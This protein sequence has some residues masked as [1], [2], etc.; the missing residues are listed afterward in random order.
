MRMGTTW[1]SRRMAAA[2]A[3]SRSMKRSCSDSR[4]RAGGIM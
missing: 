1:K 3:I 2:G 4:R